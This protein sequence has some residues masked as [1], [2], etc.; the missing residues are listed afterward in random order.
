MLELEGE[1]PEVFL[2]PGEVYLA[3]KPTIIRTILGSCVGVTFWNARLGVGALCHAL[4]PRCPKNPTLNLSLPTGRRYV[5]FSITDLAR[6]FDQLG[7]LR[8]EV[9]I[10]VF[11]GADVLPVN[12]AASAR[13]TVGRQNCETALEVLRSEGYDI[14]ASSL[15]GTCGRSI[16]FHTGTGEVLLRRLSRVIFEDGVDEL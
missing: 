12:D 6:Q 4:L 9:Q 8:P 5:D 2:Q 11:G 13:A 15:G 1:L 14:T 16:Q 10:K 3:R 7:A